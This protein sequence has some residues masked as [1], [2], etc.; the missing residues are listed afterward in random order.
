MCLQ[1]WFK[2]CGLQANINS[3]SDLAETHLRNIWCLCE[4]MLLS[5]V[6]P[7]FELSLAAIWEEVNKHGIFFIFIVSNVVDQKNIQVFF[8]KKTK[9][10]TIAVTEKGTCKKHFSSFFF[11]FEMFEIHMKDYHKSNVK[12]GKITTFQKVNIPFFLGHKFEPLQRL[13][14]TVANIFYM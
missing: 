12:H 4:N 8:L 14:H 7:F 11:F 5:Y 10:N 3:F 6:L 9:K 1:R 2:P 13:K